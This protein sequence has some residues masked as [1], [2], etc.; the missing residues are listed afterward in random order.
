MEF[1]AI[2]VLQFLNMPTGDALLSNKPLSHISDAKEDQ[3]TSI[4]IWCL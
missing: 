3:G 4:V 1:K 2:V